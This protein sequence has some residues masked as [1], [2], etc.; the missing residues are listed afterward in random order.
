MRTDKRT[1]EA[2]RK[3]AAQL[4]DAL[5]LTGWRVRGPVECD[6]TPGRF[7]VEAETVDGTRMQIEVTG[8]PWHNDGTWYR[9]EET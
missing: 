5:A 7:M 2:T 3:V 6:K 4:R 1:A 8:E 9:R